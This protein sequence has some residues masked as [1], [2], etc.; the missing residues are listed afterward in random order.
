[1]EILK[2]ENK[3]LYFCGDFNIN[4]LNSSNHVETDN[5]INNLYS[6]SMFLLISKPTRLTHNTATLIGNIFTYDLDNLKI[7][8]GI[9]ITDISDHFHNFCINSNIKSYCLAIG[10]TLII[11]LM[12]N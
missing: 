6:S 4:L 5:F 7:T 8:P 9:L 10:M 1:M 2:I 11:P 3:H 12:L